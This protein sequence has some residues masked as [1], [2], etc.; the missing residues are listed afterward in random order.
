MRHA[1]RVASGLDS[2]VLGEPQILGQVKQSVRTAEHSGHAGLDADPP[3]PA[4]LL[5]GQGGA[6]RD[7]ASARSRS[8]WRPRRCKLAAEPLRRPRAAR[9]ML[10]IGAGEMVELAA[11]YFVA[12]RPRSRGRRQPHARARR[13]LRRA[14]RRHAPSRSSEL[15]ERLHD[16]DIV[17]TGT[18]SH[19]AR[20]SAR[21]SSSARSRRGATG[22]CSSSTSPCRATWSPRSADL[23]DVFLY[24]I[25]DLGTIV[26]EGVDERQAA[27]AEAEA[28]VDRA[29]AATSMHWLEAREPR[30]PPSSQ[31]R[32]HG[33]RVPR[34]RARRARCARL[35]KGD[36]PQAVLEALA[37]R[38]RQQVPAP[39]DAR[40]CTRAPRERARRAVRAIE[41]LFPDVGNGRT[42][43]SDR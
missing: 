27:V 23:D 4:D 7:G 1:F 43:P 12:Q 25:D 30:C 8:R 21:A 41:I 34:G 40:R 36:D 15:P 33:R 24:T 3:L 14:L 2:M 9:S 17:I 18:A 29:G 10:L 31:L 13:G 28:I 19:A 22:R 6:H 37:T 20:S 32:D 26:Q 5:G 16:F 38:A 42:T 11:T 35:A 39:P